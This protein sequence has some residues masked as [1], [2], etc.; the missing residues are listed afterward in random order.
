M[1]TW[2]VVPSGNHLETILIRYI[3]VMIRHL[4]FTLAVLALALPA[5]AGEKAAEK[6]D[7]KGG[8]KP[9]AQY[10]DLAPVALPVIVNG[11]LA[12]YVFA[13]VRIELTNSA[14]LIKL[15]TRE[16][17]FR[18]ALVRA[19]HRTPFTDPRDYNAIDAPSLQA[20]LK[21]DVIAL[22]SVQ[23]IKAVTVLSQTPRNHLAAPAGLKR[24]G[25]GE[26]HP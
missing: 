17:Y 19:A 18:D 23:D 20:T 7:E 2:L 10:V 11:R 8:L 16:P 3:A 9:V 13:K 15:R 25:A 26:I 1:E 24:P 14:N 5:A 4:S 22:S 21:R 6:K 12:N